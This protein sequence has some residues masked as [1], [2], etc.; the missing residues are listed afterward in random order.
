MEQVEVN[1]TKT[2]I[3]GFIVLIVIC[4][5]FLLLSK[6]ESNPESRR[7]FEKSFKLK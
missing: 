4:L 6:I 7:M 3:I 2:L 5:N 1:N